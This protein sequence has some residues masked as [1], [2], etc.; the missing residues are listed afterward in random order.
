M[1][2]ILL[3]S[4]IICALGWL[5]QIVAL[6]AVVFYYMHYCGCQEPDMEKLKEYVKESWLRTLHIK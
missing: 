1:K 3:I 6:R 2:L 4:T 5:S